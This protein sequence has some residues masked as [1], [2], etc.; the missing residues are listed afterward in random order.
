MPKKVDV[1]FAG[2]TF[3]LSEK[4]MGVA[5]IWRKHLRE[6]KV[7]LIFESLDTA[8]IELVKVADGVDEGGWG[9]VDLGKVINVAK[10]LPVIV[11]GLTNSIDDIA[12]LLFAYSP[13]LAEDRE[14]ILEHAY[15]TEA[16]TA[17]MEVLTL[18]FPIM[19]LWALVSGPVAARTPTNSPLPSGATG[20]RGS[21][22]KQKI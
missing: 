1:F 15:D 11:N 6:S 14:W 8:M 9:N 22:R 3:T 20:H 5:A 19:G 12:D 18:A 4:P 16:V 21:G 2:R 10:I 13:E 7:M 17:F